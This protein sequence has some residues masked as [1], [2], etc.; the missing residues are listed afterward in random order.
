MGAPPGGS[1]RVKN[2]PGNGGDIGSVS[3]LQIP[4]R[5]NK[6]PIPEFLWEI[7]W[8]EDPRANTTWGHKE[9]HVTEHWLME[10][11]QT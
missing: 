2:L 10:M 7:P 6:Q 9:L 1:E 8:T 5:G 4:W 3:E 11:Y